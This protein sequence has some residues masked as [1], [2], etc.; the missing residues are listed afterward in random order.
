MGCGSFPVEGGS[1]LPCLLSTLEE[2]ML[3]FLFCSTSLRDQHSSRP[4]GSIIMVIIIT[5]RSQIYL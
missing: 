5:K 1:T 4:H 3:P 2:A